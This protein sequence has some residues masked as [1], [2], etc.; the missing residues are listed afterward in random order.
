MG[1]HISRYLEGSRHARARTAFE[2]RDAAAWHGAT[3]AA[4]AAIA[5]Y[6]AVIAI[7]AANCSSCGGGGGGYR[8]GG[9]PLLSW[10]VEWL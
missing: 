8:C 5:S 7:S 1:V 9:G 3:P 4:A 6:C 10:K 2:W